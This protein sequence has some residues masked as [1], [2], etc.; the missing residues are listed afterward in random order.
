MA[1]VDILVLFLNLWEKL[2]A[3]TVEYAVS[4]GFVTYGVYYVEV[5][6]LYAHFDDSSCCEWILDFVKCFSASIDMSIRFLFISFMWCILLIDL[7]KLN[8]TSLE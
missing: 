6:P 3:F 4:C 7:Q 1:K 8:Q 5:C 2:V